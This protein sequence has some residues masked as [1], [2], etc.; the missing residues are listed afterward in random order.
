MSN[1]YLSEKEKTDLEMQV[2]DSKKD[3]P[4]PAYP[5]PVVDQP[6][7]PT[8]TVVQAPVVLPGVV[9]IQPTGMWKKPWNSLSWCDSEVCLAC[10]YVA[11]Y[12]STSLFF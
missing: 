3:S 4:P 5:D 10:W 8:A 9:V 6:S 2:E 7:A 12:S 11:N 1:R